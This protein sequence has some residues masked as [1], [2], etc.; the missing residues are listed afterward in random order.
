MN[1]IHKFIKT[2]TLGFVLA[3]ALVIMPSSAYSARTVG[4]I[5]TGEIDYYLQ[6]H[7]ALVDSI[8]DTKDVK[9]MMQV[10]APEPM[11]W[12]N[13]AR[14]LVVLGSEIIVTYGAPATLAVMKETSS[15]PV[16]FAGV[17]DPGKMNI[18]GKNATGIS[19]KISLTDLIS[20]LQKI[21]PFSKLGVV[22]NKTEK[23]TIL[24]VMEI[25][26][27]EGSMG[28]KASLFDS[29]KKGFSARIKGVGALL[30]TTSCTA[31]CEI[32]EI[33]G[34]AREAKI[35]TASTITGG[36]D[37]GILITVVADP[38]EQGSVAGLM[39]MRVIKGDAISSIPQQQPQKY[40]MIVN[41][42]EASSL[43]LTIPG[44]ITSAAT[45]VIK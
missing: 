7:K 43:G 20:N 18:S 42:Q 29:R 45:R 30:M 25:K 12:T 19:S 34:L 3:C 37:S 33:V 11:A 27:L 15:I 8:G 6:I 23:D 10:P 24:Q 39:V 32:M 2:V 35:P 44:E 22:F 40:L 1:T 13:A 36:E 21:K 5:L 41:E 26:K 17:Y 38:I 16:I 31:K 28:F 9:F 14:K 4:V